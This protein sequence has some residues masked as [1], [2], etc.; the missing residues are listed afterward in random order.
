[1]LEHLSEKMTIQ[2]LCRKFLVSPT[3]LKENF[4]RAYG[5]TDPYLAD[6]AAHKTW[7][8]LLCTTQMTI[9]EIAQAVGYESISQFHTGV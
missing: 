3:F 1:M 9:R 6:S 8:E 2:L 5:G 7:A 4:R